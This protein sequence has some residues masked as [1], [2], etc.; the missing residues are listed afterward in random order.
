MM[1]LRWSV[2]LVLA[3]IV[4]GPVLACGFCVSLNGNPLALPHPK[5]IEIAVAT[6]AAIEKGQLNEKCLVP[7]ATIFESGGGMIALY[8]VPAPLLV[9]AWA[10]Q[11]SGPKKSQATWNVHFLFIDTEEACG[12]SVRGG[13]VVFEAKPSMHSDARI[14]TTRTAFGALLTGALSWPEARKRGLVLLEGDAP[15]ASIP[16]ISIDG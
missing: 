3:A 13:A 5:A 12:L 1:T 2:V 7:Q 6:R 11:C 10:R 9:K 4:P 14:V 8:K 15:A 16:S